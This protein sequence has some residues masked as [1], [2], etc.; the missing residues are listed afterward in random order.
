MTVILFGASFGF[1]ILIYSSAALLYFVIPERNS[2]VIESAQGAFDLCLFVFLALITW[3]TLTLQS[4]F[5]GIEE[6]FNIHR[7]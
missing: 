5:T 3:S 4:I 7:H 1:F 6:G 2:F